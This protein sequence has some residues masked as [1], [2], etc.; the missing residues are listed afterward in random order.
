[1]HSQI[2]LNIERAKIYRE[3]T[4]KC[5]HLVTWYQLPN[6]FFGSVFSAVASG[7]EGVIL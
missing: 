2:I 3:R 6:I 7:D 4:E 1:M 5:G